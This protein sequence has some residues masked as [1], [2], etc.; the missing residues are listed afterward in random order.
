MAKL[1]TARQSAMQASPA[2]AALLL[3]PAFA[4]PAGP[5]RAE[6]QAPDAVADRAAF[7]KT[8]FY[9]L[10]ENTG[11]VLGH[12]HALIGTGYF[13][14]GLGDRAQVGVRPQEFLF[15]TPNVHGKLQLLARGAIEWSA[16]VEVL[17]LLPGATSVFT[18]S[19]FVSRID[20][21]RG[22]LW[23]VPVGSTLSWYPASFA[24][25]HTTLSA[26]SVGGKEQPYYASL[27]L[28]TVVELRALR[29][30]GL[31]FHAA[32]IGFWRHDLFVMGVSW[33]LNLGWFAAQVGYFYR[34]SPDGRQASP[35]L[36]L[37][38]TL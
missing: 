15:R 1:S 23:V 37:G 24:A 13:E 8:G 32:E 18:S 29:N 6:E 28:S 33:R 4:L 21:T 25:I 35:L 17:A 5:A 7:S 22:A 16:H 30:H 12:Q 27:G 10:W 14:L 3:A 34:I 38:V 11:G 19:N 20:N 9:P 31:L 36:S 2:L 26:M